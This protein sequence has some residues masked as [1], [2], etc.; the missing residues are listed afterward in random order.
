MDLF[1][2]RNDEE[3]LAQRLREGEVAALREFYARYAGSLAGV[4]AR[5]I[6]DD[7]DLK[8]VIGKIE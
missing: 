2:R 3:R 1:A 7:D 4:C 5:Y 8:E 6:A